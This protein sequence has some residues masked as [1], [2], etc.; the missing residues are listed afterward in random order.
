MV[1]R[2]PHDDFTDNAQCENGDHPS[3]MSP[4]LIILATISILLNVYFIFYFLMKRR[5]RS[6]HKIANDSENPLKPDATKNEGNTNPEFNVESPPDED[7][8]STNDQEHAK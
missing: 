2:F 8:K 7:L 6:K 4:S 1:E 3:S 5:E